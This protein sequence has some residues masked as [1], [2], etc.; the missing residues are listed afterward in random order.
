[1]FGPKNAPATQVQYMYL[2][3]PP[4]HLAHT[5]NEEAIIRSPKYRP[6]KGVV[7]TVTQFDGIPMA[8]MFKVVHYWSFDSTAKSA[9]QTSASTTSSS[10]MVRV[11][12]HVH[13]TKSTM[14][15]GQ[16]NSGVKDELTVLSKKWCVRCLY[17]LFLLSILFTFPLFLFYFV[18]YLGGVYYEIPSEFIVIP[19]TT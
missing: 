13:F 16:I 18:T 9:N 15:K 7:V 1:M 17:N 19:T 11:G 14:F 10:C 8:D 12:L 2:S 4:P 6:V 3:R 5:Q